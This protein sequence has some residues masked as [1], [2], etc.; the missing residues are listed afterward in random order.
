MEDLKDI[1]CQKKKKFAQNRLKNGF[2]N[3]FWVGPFSR[4]GGGE[5]L[6]VGLVKI[7]SAFFNYKFIFIKFIPKMFH[8]N[9]LSTI[10]SLENGISEAAGNHRGTQI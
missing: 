2:K 9:I 3:F 1:L 10:I 6:Y 7:A 5:G 8:Q 4:K